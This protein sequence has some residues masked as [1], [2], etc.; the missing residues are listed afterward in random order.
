MRRVL[1]AQRALPANV[2]A[3]GWVSFANDVASELA[4]PIVPLFLRTTLGASYTI[5]GIIEGIAEGVAVGFRGL[6]GRLSDLGGERRKPWIAVGY[7]LTT[8][9]RPLLAVANGWGLVLGARL[10][11]RAGK[12]ARTAPRDALIRDSTPPHQLGSSFG[13]HRAMDSA[14]A[15]IGPLAAVGLLSLLQVSLRTALWVV[16]LPSAVALALVAAVRDAPPA[17]RQELAPRGRVRDLPPAFWGVLSVWILFSIGNSADVFLLL[18][19]R[20]I[21][22]GTSLTVVA[23]ALYQLVYSGLSWPLGAL[24]DRIPR[25]WILAAGLA[26]FTLVYLGFA[27]PPGDWAV[28]P[29]LA[30][31]GAYVAATDGV[32]RAVVGDHAPY[33]LVGTAFGVFSAATGAALL[34]ASVAAGLLWSKVSPSAPFYVG[35]AAA[36]LALVVLVGLPSTG[37]RMRRAPT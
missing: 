29:L 5:I 30:V 20:Q 14:G 10:A 3:L 23:Y 31:Y 11:D 12:A 4:Y 1:E 17:A 9:S 19:A 13:Y 6:A 25:T 34:L 36:A 37:Y 8:L 7:G 16:V 28:W 26:V 2:R 33:G 18:R 24:S 27:R 22:L 21:G 32:A 15:V 35:A